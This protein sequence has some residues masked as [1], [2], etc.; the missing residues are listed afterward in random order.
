MISAVIFDFY[1]VFCSDAYLTWQDSH[2]DITDP[3]RQRFNA[4]ASRNDAGELTLAEFYAEAAAIASL[5]LEQTITELGNAMKLD[6]SVVDLT[7][8]LRDKGIKIGLLSN[9]PT[10][11]YDTIDGFGIRSLFDSVL[12]S[13][14]AGASKPKPEI[15]ALILAKLSASA[16]KSVF[17][18][19]RQVN[20][21]GAKRAGLIGILFTTATELEHRLINL[22]VL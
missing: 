18:D 12:C 6:Q 8:R 1:G 20:I 4:L 3:V 14:E 17:V 2:F 16:S 15:F 11:L 7:G 21:D 22:G 10:S 5:P 9:S 19:D 13:A